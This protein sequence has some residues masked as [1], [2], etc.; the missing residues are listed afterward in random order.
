MS[1]ES[2]ISTIGE[3]ARTYFFHITQEQPERSYAIASYSLGSTVAFEISKL[4][5]LASKEVKF[6][7]LIDS[8]PHNQARS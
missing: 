8:P 2:F 7:S 4:L 5:E 6:P 3:I 1:D